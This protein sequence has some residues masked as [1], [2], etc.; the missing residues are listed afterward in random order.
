MTL[1]PA[2][3]DK[4]HFIKE[5]S[6]EDSESS[7]WCFLPLQQ[8]QYG[9]WGNVELYDS[10]GDKILPSDNDV[11]MVSEKLKIVGGKIVEKPSLNW[12]NE[13]RKNL[14]YHLEFCSA[15]K[16]RCHSCKTI[17]SLKIAEEEE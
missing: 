12:K 14:A 7:G 1:E 16:E 8:Q 4:V 3:G 6:S 15:S 11:R 2:A 9:M 5:Y 10:Y 13:L 17:D